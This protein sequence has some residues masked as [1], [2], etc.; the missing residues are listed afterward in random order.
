M[1]KR[2]RPLFYDEQLAF[3]ESARAVLATYHGIPF[4]QFG[5]SMTFPAW[6]VSRYPRLGQ[7]CNLPPGKPTDRQ[8]L[9]KYLSFLLGGSLAEMIR[10]ERQRDITPASRSQ[11]R[12]RKRW[13]EEAWDEPEPELDLVYMAVM[14]WLSAGGP[15]QV[16]L[17]RK[18]LW[19]TTCHQLEYPPLWPA[20][21]KIAERML[22]G[23]I[24]EKNDVLELIS[25]DEI[26]RS[27]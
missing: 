10:T 6:P 21:E 24:I 22:E 12:F 18:R 3:R 7:F 17:E 26:Q 13:Y 27:P 14:A 5:L 4:V 25:P 1:S 2:K 11:K 23:E 19:D 16:D 9:E 20:V 8:S 15:E